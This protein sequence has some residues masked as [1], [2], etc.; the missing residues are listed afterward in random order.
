[1][2]THQELLQLTDLKKTYEKGQY[3]FGPVTLSFDRGTT[4]GVLGKN[5]AGK[6]TL[7]QMI[8]G[9]LIPSEGRISVGGHR[10]MLD[11][12]EPKRS[13][14][15]LPQALDLPR[16]VTAFELLNYA[17]QLYG[18]ENPQK[19]R[20]AALEYWDCQSFAHKPLAACS[21]GMQKRVG[22]ALSTIH[23]PKLLILD[24]PFSGLDLYHIRALQQS[25]ARRKEEG[26]LTMLSTHIAPYAAQLCNQAILVEQGNVALHKT[27]P[28]INV[29]QRIDAIEQFFFGDKQSE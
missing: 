2:T 17:L 5:G 25:I 18:L 23:E 10:I 21:H 14:G 7:F 19:R 3:I 11:D 13:I 28:D 29:Q 1:M 4:L 26:L 22:L 8:T 12:P 6:T 20:D 27:W 16:W 9:N 15:Y 24:E